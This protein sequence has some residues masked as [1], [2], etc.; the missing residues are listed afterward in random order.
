MKISVVIP[1]RNRPDHIRKA[2]LSLQKQTYLPAEVIIVDSSDDLAYSKE[3]SRQSMPFSLAWLASAPSVCVQRNK[4]ISVASNSWVFLCDDDIELAENYLQKLFEYAVKNPECGVVAGRLLQQE[5][6]KWID[7][8]SPKNFRNLVWYFIF[9]L[10]I[11]GDISKIQTSWIFTP[12][13]N[14]I[15]RWY[16]KRS[17]R[18]TLS[19]FPL[20]TFWDGRYFTTKFYSLG[21]NLIKKE[22][23]FNSP[24]D[25][26]LD[27]S[28]IGDN[29]GVALGFPGEQPI[30]VLA[31]AHAYHNRAAENR[32]KQ[33]VT[34]YRR[35]LAL[36]Y[37][38]KRQAKNYLSTTVWFCWSLTGSAMLHASKGNWKTVGVT[39]KALTVIVFGKNPYWQGYIKNDKSVQP[40]V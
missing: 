16:V 24:Y 34:Y 26:V 27:P 15:K 21:A 2:L 30:H 28:G 32:L 31:C 40:S 18:S 17:N 23:L 37:F 14:F 13:L 9:Q 33:E 10:P 25:E 19:G 3:V 20:I 29:Y 6:G 38:L 22:W 36:N 39:L 5:A 7:Q 4:G 35:I 1:T 8:Y 12:I 11:W